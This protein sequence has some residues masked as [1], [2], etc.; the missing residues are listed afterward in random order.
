MAPVESKGDLNRWE[1]IVLTFDYKWKGCGLCSEPCLFPCCCCQCGCFHPMSVCMSQ[2]DKA[3]RSHNMVHEA[4]TKH[5]I[6]GS[7]AIAV[8]FVWE[9]TD[10]GFKAT[11]IFRNIDA[12]EEYYTHFLKDKVFVAKLLTN[13]P[14]RQSSGPTANHGDGN[15]GAWVTVPE[16]GTLE[17]LLAIGK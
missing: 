12:A 9:E 15:V 5:G 17:E 4:Y 13:L 2:R 8:S 16:G 3:V 7:N 10:Y 14:F 11:E 6:Y 1:P